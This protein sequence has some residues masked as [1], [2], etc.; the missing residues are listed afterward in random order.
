VIGAALALTA[1]YVALAALVLHLNLVAPRPRWVKVSAAVVVTGFYLCAWHGALGLLGWPAPGAPAGAVRVHAVWLDEPDRA[2]TTEGGVYFWVRALDPNGRPIGEP[3][4]HALP[5]TR[6]LA[7]A[8]QSAQEEL[9]GGAL[10]DGYFTG[11]KAETAQSDARGRGVTDRDGPLLGATQDER[12]RFEF[13]R[14]ARPE[15]PPKPL[16]DALD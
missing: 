2:G 3:R 12:P 8:A 1:A 7:E 9:A 15:L 6:E 5:W 4:A 13:R 14:V 10:L 11:S 16:P